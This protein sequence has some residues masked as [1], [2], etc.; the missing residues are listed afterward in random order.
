VL[1]NK[2]CAFTGDAMTGISG[3]AVPTW[4]DW[5]DEWLADAYE[6]LTGETAPPR[7]SGGTFMDADAAGSYEPDEEWVDEETAELV[8]NNLKLIADHKPSQ[9]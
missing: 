6:A 9:G 1:A 7:Q 2:F 5:V 3:D 4:D 8:M